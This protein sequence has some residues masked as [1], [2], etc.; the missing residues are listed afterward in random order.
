M[1]IIIREVKNYGYI[2]IVKDEDGKEVY[3]GEFQPT[4]QEALD[5]CEKRILDIKLSKVKW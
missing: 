5:R 4:A 2:P 3:R 1:D